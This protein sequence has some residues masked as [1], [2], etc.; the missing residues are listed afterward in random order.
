MKVWIV[1]MLN[2]AY[3][4]SVPKWQPTVGCSLTKNDGL[5]ELKKWKK[6][7]CGKFRLVKYVST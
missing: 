6:R 5:K 1:E 7:N 2:D 4:E 3:I